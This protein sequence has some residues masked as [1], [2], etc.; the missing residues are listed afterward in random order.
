VH[1][2]TIDPLGADALS[3]SALDGVIDAEHDG[4]LR[5]EV[6]DEESEQDAARLPGIPDGAIQ[7]AV[8]VDEVP[9]PAVAHDAQHASDRAC[10]RS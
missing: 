10:A 2:I 1:R 6:R 8:E 5:Y 3:S 4:T 9:I 7:Y